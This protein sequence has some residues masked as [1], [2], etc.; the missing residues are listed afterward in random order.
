MRQSDFQPL[1]AK[2]FVIVAIIMGVFLSGCWFV[3][4]LLAKTKEPNAIHG[5]HQPTIPSTP[6]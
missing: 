1:D 5:S 3:G 4:S 6:L 2:D